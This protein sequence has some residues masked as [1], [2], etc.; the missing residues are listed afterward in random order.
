M[1][2][3][4]IRLALMKITDLNEL[5]EINEVLMLQYRSLQA[6]KTAHAVAAFRKGDR[7]SFIGKNGLKHFGTVQ[8]VNQ[9]TVT[10]FSDRQ[11]TWRIT[12]G[13]LSKIA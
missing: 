5:R 9:K 10:V 7:V 6:V 8:K 3:K 12:P 13:L 11:S 1:T 2:S 4:E